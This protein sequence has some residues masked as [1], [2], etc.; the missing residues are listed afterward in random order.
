MI[1]IWYIMEPQIGIEKIIRSK[2][3]F[4]HYEIRFSKTKCE[5]TDTI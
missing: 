4:V 2:H 3:C 5:F 1:I